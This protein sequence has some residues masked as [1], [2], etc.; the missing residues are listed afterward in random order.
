MFH[1][2]FIWTQ[3]E[4]PTSGSLHL[5]ELDQTFFTADGLPAVLPLQYQTFVGAQGAADLAHNQQ[6]LDFVVVD[7]AGVAANSEHHA[8]MRPP[9]CALRVTEAQV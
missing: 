2:R 4:R 6:V 8:V 9:V 7:E 5:L 1:K 3:T